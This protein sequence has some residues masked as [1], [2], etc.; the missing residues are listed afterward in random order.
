[1]TRMCKQ[2][3]DTRDT[4]FK[5]I[6]IVKDIFWGPNTIVDG[7]LKGSQRDIGF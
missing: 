6:N 3:H 2:K 1:M 4:V 7:V 5:L